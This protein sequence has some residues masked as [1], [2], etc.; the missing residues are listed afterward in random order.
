MGVR[1]LAAFKGLGQRSMSGLPLSVGPM[2][3]P[4]GRDVVD[5]QAASLGHENAARCAGRPGQPV[6]PAP[7]APG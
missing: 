3:K 6:L 1:H 7:R 4:P 2:P 5:A